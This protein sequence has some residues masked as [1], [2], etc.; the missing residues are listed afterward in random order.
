M[1]ADDTSILCAAKDINNLKMKI[2]IVL[3]HMSMWFQSSQFALNLHKT[4]MIKFIPTS[5]TNIE[6]S[7]YNNIFRGT[8]A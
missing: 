3:M 7:R 5:A 8:V 4:Q 2:D 6:S 1:F